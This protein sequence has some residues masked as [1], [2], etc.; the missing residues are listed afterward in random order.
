MSFSEKNSSN[1]DSKKILAKK[2][3]GQNFLVNTQIQEKISKTMQAFVDEYP[4][5]V[6]IEIGP[7]RGDLT[8]H[9]LAFNRPLYAIEIDPDL[10][11]HLNSQF[12]DNT[13][14]NLF[15]NN[16]T[17]ILPKLDS[18]NPLLSTNSILLSNLPFSVGSR[19][20]VDLATWYPNI[21]FAVILQKEVSDKL[22]KTSSFTLFAAFLSLFYNFSQ[23][24]SISP[25]AFY[26]QPKVV[27]SLFFARPKILNL[28]DHPFLNNQKNRL[29]TLLLL[30]TLFGQPSKTLWNNLKQ[31]DLSQNEIEE[32][33]LQ[34]SW[35][36]NIRL[37]WDNYE[38]I[39][40]TIL[41]IY[42]KSDS[43]QI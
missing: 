25:N 37:T 11:D 13:L 3:L 30:K 22:K 41:K 31:T 36:K 35:S 23:Q 43:K 26:P 33:Y 39:L 9:F 15:I 27:S 16:F 10:S 24:F 20:L 18:L 4:D 29:F 12:S 6:L 19:I 38:K 28:N 40:Q 32:L 21:P 34:N 42:L 17:D 1:L 8:K 2:S 5:K 7:G 14:F